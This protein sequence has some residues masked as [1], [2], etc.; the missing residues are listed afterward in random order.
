MPK[1]KCCKFFPVKYTQDAQ[2]PVVH[3]KD[4]DKVDKKVEL[5]C[6]AKFS[7]PLVGPNFDLYTIE[8]FKEGKPV[9]EVAS[10]KDRYVLGTHN[11]TLNGVG[12]LSNNSSDSQ[13]YSYRRMYRL[14]YKCIVSF[15]CYANDAFYIYFFFL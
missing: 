1:K 11:I 7:N 15:S 9:K 6:E 3:N 14:I 10:L 13:S 8:W 12:K 5:K 4:K 2:V